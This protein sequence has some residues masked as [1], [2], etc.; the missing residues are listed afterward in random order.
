MADT[1]TLDLDPLLPCFCGIDPGFTGAFAWIDG[2]GQSMGYVDMPV[3]G[4]GR[5]REFDLDKLNKIVYQFASTARDNIVI[6]GLE[7]PTSMPGEGAHRSHRFGEGIGMLK[8][9]MIAHQLPFRLVPPNLWKGRLGL[10]GKTDPNANNAG[11]QLLES[12]YSTISSMIRGPRG[13]IKDGRL[14]AFLIAHWIKEEHV[15]TSNRD[16][17]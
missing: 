1:D 4:K 13:G 16:T 5:G 3:T 14:D 12:H 11:A 17:R 9:L 2:D 8:G 15:R 6:V 7:K 10:P